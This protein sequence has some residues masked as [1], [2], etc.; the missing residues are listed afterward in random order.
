[1][2]VIK[3][4]PGL[5]QFLGRFHQDFGLD[6]E[7][8]E[9]AINEF[10]DTDNNETKIKLLAEITE[11]LRLYGNE[12]E[13]IYNSGF[14]YDDIMVKAGVGYMPMPDDMSAYDWLVMIKKRLIKVI[15]S[16]VEE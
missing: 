3:K 13:K 16:K 6:G 4:F 1:M 2:I 9:D 12:L 14:A 10:M 7:T 11:F 15:G 5:W 8:V